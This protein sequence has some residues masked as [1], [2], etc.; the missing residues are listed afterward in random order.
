[1]SELQIIDDEVVSFDSNA[2]CS[3]E[4]FL[5]NRRASYIQLIQCKKIHIKIALL[6]IES[7]W[8]KFAINEGDRIISIGSF[9]KD[10]KF[11]NASLIYSIT[12]K[13]YIFDY[14]YFYI[15]NTF[16]ISILTVMLLVMQGITLG[17]GFFALIWYFLIY[18]CLQKSI[19]LTQD[20]KLISKYLDKNIGIKE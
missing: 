7:F 15:F 17:F 16:A 5:N 10:N 6:I 9:D 11:F 14:S 2:N 13:R 12:M 19:N 3:F 20:K 8:N 18:F 4:S 1:M